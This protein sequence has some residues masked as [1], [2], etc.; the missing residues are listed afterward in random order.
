[1]SKLPHRF[2]TALVFFILLTFIGCKGSDITEPHSSKSTR[3]VGGIPDS[4]KFGDIVV[5]NGFKQQMEVYKNGSIDSNLII[6]KLYNRHRI[7]WDSCYGMIFGPDN[8][9]KFQTPSGMVNWNEQL[10]FKDDS[11]I[12]SLIKVVQNYNIDSLFE[13]HNRRFDSLG[14]ETPEAKITI[15]FTPFPGIGFGGCARDQFILEL[16]NPEFEIIY[17]L[18]KGLPHE[19]YHFINEKNLGEVPEMNA[20]DLAINEGLA[21]HFTHHY[22]EGEITKYEAVENMTETDWNYYVKREKKI[23]NTMKQYFDDTSG[24]NPLLRNKQHD[25]FKDSPRSIQYWLGYR[26]VESYLDTH[27]GKSLKDLSYMSYEEIYHNSGYAEKFEE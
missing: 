7:M 8:A 10:L 16:N 23:Y 3:E 11:K 15:A 17:T 1:M 20:L 18:E 13:F 14:Y 26:I 9:D 4:L 22:F 6:D 24:N 12:D 5:Y 25:V 19:I 2:A 21:C 27:S